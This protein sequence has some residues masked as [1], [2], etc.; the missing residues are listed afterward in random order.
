MSEYP[1]W[2]NVSNCCDSI[3]NGNTVLFSGLNLQH[4]ILT[5]YSSL[6]IRDYFSYCFQERKIIL[7]YW[8]M[9]QLEKYN[10]TKLHLVLHYWLNKNCSWGELRLLDS[11]LHCHTCYHML[12]YKIHPHTYSTHY[13]EVI[14]QDAHS[15]A[16]TGWIKKN[17]LCIS[18]TQTL[19]Q[20]FG[21]AITYIWRT[22]LPQKHMLIMLSVAN[23]SHTRYFPLLNT[24]IPSFACHWS[25]SQTSNPSS[26]LPIIRLSEK[27][28]KQRGQ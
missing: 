11:I 8:R 18:D 7:T 15:H 27:Y 2:F 3:W 16:A 12:T 22:T 24:E 13:T 21:S 28:Q 6:S 10:W 19:Y 14:H 20:I 5:Q 9:V 17:S 4:L 1:V 25:F 26:I 23:G